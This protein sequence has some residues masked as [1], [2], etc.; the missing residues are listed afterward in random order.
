MEA[1]LWN[2]VKFKQN[3]LAKFLLIA[4]F[5]Y[6]NTK[7]ANISPIFYKINY[8]YYFIFCLKIILIFILNC[9]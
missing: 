5:I 4:K 3:N 2:F 6:N 9:N 1:Y 7:N 8:K